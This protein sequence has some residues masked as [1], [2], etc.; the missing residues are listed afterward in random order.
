MNLLVDFILHCMHQTADHI[1]AAIL[2][3]IPLTAIFYRKRKRSRRTL[4]LCFLTAWSVA[5]IFAMTLLG[6]ELGSTQKRFEL[7]L[8]WSY[9][10]A[11]LRGSTE[12]GMEI[13]ANILLFV[14]AGICLPMLFPFFGSIRHMITAACLLS[15]GI[16]LTQ[17]I[18][19]MGLFE[20]DDILNNTAG[21]VLGWAVYCGIVHIMKK[22]HPQQREVS[23]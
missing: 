9:K 15:L 19:G 6:R 8:F 18:T 16:E 13:A 2:L 20:F 1:G 17:G 10:E 23:P 7:E 14:P 21:A 22:K 3:T 12:M 5:H 4:L 11:L